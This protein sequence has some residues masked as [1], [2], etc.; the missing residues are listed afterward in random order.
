MMIALP[1]KTKQSS[2]RPSWSSTRPSSRF[3]PPFV[4]CYC[5]G[6]CDSDDYFE[7]NDA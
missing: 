4:D 6:G 3:R 7:A 2:D 5:G 1:K